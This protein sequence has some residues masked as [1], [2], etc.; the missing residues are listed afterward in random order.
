MP[1]PFSIAVWSLEKW[2]IC[3]VTLTVFKCKERVGYNS[4]LLP[5]APAETA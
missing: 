3:V 4:L 5:G 2:F 1:N